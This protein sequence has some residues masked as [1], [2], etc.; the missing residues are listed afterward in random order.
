MELPRIIRRWNY[1]CV[2]LLSFCCQVY[3]VF[4]FPGSLCSQALQKLPDTIWEFSGKVS[5]SVDSSLVTYFLKLFIQDVMVCAG[6]SQFLERPR[7][8]DYVSLGVCDQ[9]GGDTGGP[10]F[11]HKMSPT[12]GTT[13]WATVVDIIAMSKHGQTWWCCNGRD[14]V[15]N[16]VLGHPVRPQVNHPWS[17]SA[18]QAL[19]TWGLSCLSSP[20]PKHTVPATASW[21]LQLRSSLPW[22]VF[23]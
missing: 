7:Q 16:T 20:T 14:W 1:C 5:V 17:M 18:D 23:H 3:V 13:I 4:W 11:S 21:N 19:L 12:T 6:T 9:S 10:F 8:G 22:T 15:G 2:K